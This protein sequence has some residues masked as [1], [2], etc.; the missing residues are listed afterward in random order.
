[1]LDTLASP[2]VV[3]VKSTP[4]GSRA[5]SAGEQHP[6]AR[7][8]GPSPQGRRGPRPPASS[9]DELHVVVRLPAHQLSS[10]PGQE[11]VQCGLGLG[12]DLNLVPTIPHL[13]AHEHHAEIELLIELPE[14]REPRGSGSAVRLAEGL[15]PR[16][17]HCDARGLQGWGGVPAPHSPGGWLYLEPGCHHG[18]P[19]PPV[20]RGF[21]QAGPELPGVPAAPA[22]SPQGGSSAHLVHVVDHLQHPLTYGL[23]APKPLELEDGRPSAAAWGSA[24]AHPPPPP[25]SLLHPHSASLLHPAPPRPPPTPASPLRPAPAPGTSLLSVTTNSST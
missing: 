23:S 5:A 14:D 18:C 7:A 24:P 13:Q 22:G 10:P 2:T 4:L 9:R 8:P 3:P 16:G 6:G 17:V 1:M 20:Q 19:N 11:V 12:A 25:T 15:R 21:C